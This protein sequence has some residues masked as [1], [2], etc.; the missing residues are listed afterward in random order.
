MFACVAGVTLAGQ[1]AAQAA[2]QPKKTSRQHVQIAKGD[3]T[4]RRIDTIY[5]ARTD[6]VHVSRVDT[7]VVAGRPV[8]MPYEVVRTD[9]VVVGPAPVMKGPFYASMYTGM[10]MPAGN[11][12]RLYVNGFHAGLAFGWDPAR[13]PFGF[14]VKGDVA[15]LSRENGPSA[16]AGTTTPTI[17]NFGADVKAFPLQFPD[18]RIY[19]LG[20]LLASTYR[21]MATV[22]SPA[23]GAANMD[24][25]GGSYRPASGSDWTSRFGWN[26]GGGADIHFGQQELFVEARAVAL[27]ADEAWTWFVPISLGIRF[28]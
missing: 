10:T 26:A 12:D 18:W 4:L 27:R 28:F 21:G 1:L 20:G 3:V 9:T 8:R 15:L 24:G 2:P 5:V 7:V 16:L 23:R 6:T 14:R 17:V 22:A 19:G 25:R 11:M 13:Q